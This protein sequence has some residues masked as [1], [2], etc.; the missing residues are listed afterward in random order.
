MGSYLGWLCDLVMGGLPGGCSFV[1]ILGILSD[2]VFVIF[3]GIG[4][5]LWLW[6]RSGSIP[7]VWCTNSGYVL[8]WPAWILLH[9]GLGWSALVLCTTL[10]WLQNSGAVL[11]LCLDQI[12]PRTSGVRLM[13]WL[14]GS[15]VVLYVCG[16]ACFSRSFPAFSLPGSFCF[17][18]IHW[19]IIG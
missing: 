6:F 5:L 10:V 12:L 13:L 19:K 8:L 7:L 18:Q 9:L 14:G 3:F 16:T 17:V 15:L 2:G 1:F 11:F 4:Q